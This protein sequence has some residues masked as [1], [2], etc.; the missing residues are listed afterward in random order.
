MDREDPNVFVNCG[1]SSEEMCRN[2]RRMVGRQLA[3]MAAEASIPLQAIAGTVVSAMGMSCSVP[4][5]KGLLTCRICRLA[6]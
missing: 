3:T 4:E 2:R 5:G 6:G 1:E